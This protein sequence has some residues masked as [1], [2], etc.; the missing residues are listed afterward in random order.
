MNA[1]QSLQ[2]SDHERAL[3]PDDRSKAAG[4]LK[5]SIETPAIECE[6]AKP[7][8]RA[9]F[10][11]ADPLYPQK[12]VVFLDEFA[13]PRKYF[14]ST[15]QREKRRA[16]RARTPLSIA[17]F[18]IAGAPGTSVMVIRQLLD[19]LHR[20]KRETDT[21]GDLDH[22]RFAI[23][24]PDT[25][26]EGLRIFMKRISRHVAAMPCSL[27]IGTYPNDLFDDLLRLHGEV[28]ESHPLFVDSH[29]EPNRLGSV[30]KRCID[31]VGAF[32]G[33]FLLAPIIALVGIGVATS[34]R[35]PV[36]FKQVRLG[37]GGRPFVFYKF[38]SMFC[39][40]DDRIHREYVVGLINGLDAET[41]PGEPS[42]PW[43]KLK[44]DYRIT[45]FGR[46]IRKTSLDELPQLF[47]VLIGDLSLVG[48]RPP[49]PYEA[50]KYQSWHL[51]RILETKPGISGLWQVSA[52]YEATFDDMVR[53]DLEYIRNWSLGLDFEILFKTIR[54]V[55]RRSNAG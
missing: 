15:L 42:K 45:R 19:L 36:I 32:M 23:I 31:V 14:L 35:G 29:V 52:G 3:P 2:I 24:L 28:G 39:D 50:E 41:I 17:I 48:P 22:Q 38:R 55:L 1:E 11:A 51:R 21:I 13:L 26:R 16:D 40:T 33:L 34:S 25:S 54:V 8:T 20:N 18:E 7:R 4:L 10:V 49:L 30:L 44:S 43:A 53:L 27:A 37:K 46:F 12:D 5:H 9:G 6:S 47:N